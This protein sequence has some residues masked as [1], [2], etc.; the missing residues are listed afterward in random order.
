MRK[1][2]SKGREIK[3]LNLSDKREGDTWAWY[4]KG[5]ELKNVFFGWLFVFDSKNFSPLCFLNGFA[6]NEGVGG[7]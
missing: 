4:G 1:M 3:V 2:P 6:K 7:N 5:F